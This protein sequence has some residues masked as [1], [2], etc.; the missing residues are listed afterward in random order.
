MTE[1]NQLKI[2]ELLRRIAAAVEAIAI[3]QN[4]HFRST[5]RDSESGRLT[6]YGR[7]SSQ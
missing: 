2:I 1:A 6:Q 7:Q 5:D 4:P 3:V